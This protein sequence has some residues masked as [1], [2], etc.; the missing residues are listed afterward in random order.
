MPFSEL[1]T[2]KGFPF[3]FRP[4]GLPLTHVAGTGIYLICNKNTED[5]YIGS[6]VDMCKR[7]EQ[8]LKGLCNGSHHSYLL[9]E[10]F[11]GY[12]MDSFNF[13]VLMHTKLEDLQNIE[14]VFIDFLN[15]RY[16]I[17]RIV[18]PVTYS[19]KTR[20]KNEDIDYSSEIEKLKILL[21]NRGIS[22]I[23]RLIAEC[24]VT[25]TQLSLWD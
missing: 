25:D 23:P 17:A 14:G 3:K 11:N 13:F 6:S 15:P 20:G 24:T 19:P 5:F 4:L 8:H 22:I 9:Q 21:P 7:S 10:A 1:F 12:G 16:N 2:R 18:T